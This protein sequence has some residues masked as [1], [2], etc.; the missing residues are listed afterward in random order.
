MR[1]GKTYK[2]N[3]KFA[4][5]LV[6]QLFATAA[7]AV[8]LI[9]VAQP[10]LTPSNGDLLAGFRKTGIN[11]ENYEVVANIGNIT[12]FLALS[13]G[14]QLTISRYTPGQL[15]PNAFSDFNN[16]QWS[17]FGTFKVVGTWDGFPIYTVWLTM[18]RQDPNTQTQPFPRYGESDQAPMR[19]WILGVGVG[20]AFISSSGVSNVN[21]TA[22]L[23][24]E[25]SGDAQHA[26][27]VYIGDPNDP[28]IGDF[29]G[30]LPVTVENNTS[31]SFTSPTVSDLYQ[32]CPSGDLDPVTGQTQGLTYYVGNFQFNPDGTMSFTR[33][34]T[35]S[36]VI[37]PPPPRILAVTRNANVS[38]ISFT[39]TNAA[40]YTLYFTNAAGLTAPVSS[41]PVSGTVAGDGTA[42][43]ISDTSTDPIR[44]YRVGVH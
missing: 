9:C 14:S 22:Y 33:A 15:S 38:T 1:S 4:Q 21:N 20:A 16:L 11:Q 19:Q 27:T 17:V 10:F 32:F 12:N 44:Y 34:S 3:T 40:T 42:K 5:R 30:T 6:L 43:S 35:N 36:V 13:P 26:L 2:N 41:W 37:P 23:V 24:R 28:T 29:N 25:P 18:P 7:L 31:D 39:T 8:P